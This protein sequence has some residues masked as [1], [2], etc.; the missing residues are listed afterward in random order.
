MQHLSTMQRL[1]VESRNAILDAITSFAALRPGFD[2]RNYSDRASYQAD[3]RPVTKARH[4]VQIL[5]GYIAR[6]GM[7]ADELLAGFSAWSG[8]LTISPA[9]NGTFACDYC[10]GQYFPVEFRAACRAVLIQAIE[11]RWRNEY[12]ETRGTFDGARDYIKRQARNAFGS[13][14]LVALFG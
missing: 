2:H 6:S 7:S 11:E 4:H 8:R 1:N 3:V 5:A 12:R 10:T 9:K 13:R 14:S